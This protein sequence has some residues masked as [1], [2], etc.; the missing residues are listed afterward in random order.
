M[1]VGHGTSLWRRMVCGLVLLLVMGSGISGSLALSF[2]VLE[3]ESSQP[4]EEKD[5][6]SCEVESLTPI[7]RSGWRFRKNAEVR[8]LAA[9]SLEALRNGKRR[10]SSPPASSARAGRRVLLR[11]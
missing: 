8:R 6:S 9:G 5:L 3:T 11:C 1:R 10:C 7:R 2:E 4:V